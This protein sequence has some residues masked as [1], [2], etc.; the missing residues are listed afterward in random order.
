MLVREDKCKE[1]FDRFVEWVRK[2]RGWT[3]DELAEALGLDPS[4]LS[5]GR[6][7]KNVKLFYVDLAEV[8]ECPVETIVDYIKNDDEI[9]EPVDGGDSFDELER[10]TMAEFD[11]GQFRQM[12]TLSQRMLKAGLLPEQRALACHYL[13]IAWDGLGWHTRALE[14]TRQG[15]LEVGISSSLRMRLL[16]DLANAHYMLWQLPEACGTAQLVIEWFREHPPSGDRDC[17]AEAYAYYVR[18]GTHRRLIAQE[19]ENR[20]EHAERAKADLERCVELF[21]P[22]YAR[23]NENAGAI[24]HT[25]RGGVLEAD[26]ELGLRTP[27]S[28]VEE[29]QSALDSVRDCSAFPRGYWLESYGWW[30]IFGLNIL[31]R[32]FTPTEFGQRFAILS[33]KAMEIAERADNWAFRERVLTLERTG[34]QTLSAG[35]HIG[36]DTI[37]LDAEDIRAFLGVLV[38]F[39]H[40]RG[41]GWK[42][43]KNARI[44]LN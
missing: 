32:H 1:R 16:Y 6:W 14:V 42:I 34:R 10:K 26:A 35:P 29:L 15:L 2:S 44:V 4:T 28:A 37:L 25:A 33:Q 12:A 41:F 38:R 27:T 23:G 21:S 40:F 36:Q 24:A 30:C 31:L 11:A 9:D 20:R 43:F 13:Q 19:P 5:R 7:N 8:L 3:R 39:P 17:G 22:I 18:G